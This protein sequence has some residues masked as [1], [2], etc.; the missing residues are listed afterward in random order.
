MAVGYINPQLL[1]VLAAQGVQLPG[2]PQQGAPPTAVPQ[3]NVDPLAPLPPPPQGDPRAPAQTPQEMA[4]LPMGQP[5][6]AP[7]ASSMNDGINSVGRPGD[8][9]DADA[10]ELRKLHRQ[11]KGDALMALGA[12]LLSANTFGEGL[13][14]GIQGY[15][16]V[17]Q[18]A[19]K[20]FDGKHEDVAGG[21]FD[22]YTDA[23]GHVHYNKN[24]DVA[25]Y[26]DNQKQ[27]VVDGKIY[28][29][30]KGYQKGVDVANITV[31]GGIKKTEMTT[32]AARDIA[33]GNN[34][35]SVKVAN[36][37]RAASETVANIMGKYR[38]IN[39]QPNKFEL[40]VLEG[41]Q[42]AGNDM[43]TYDN[44]ESLLDDGDTGAGAGLLA[45]GT[46]ALAGVTGQDIGG[47]NVNHM[48]QMTAYTNQMKAKAS[49]MKGQGQISNYERTIMDQ[50]LPSLDTNPDSIRAIIHVFRAKSDRDSRG[51]GI[52]P[53]G[54][55]YSLLDAVHGIKGQSEP[56][57]QNTT[58]TGTK[59]RVVH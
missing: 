8:Q 32:D 19:R 1:A 6:Q 26:L 46:R 24:K 33:A 55:E 56:A 54:T 10:K 14:K 22:K 30:D 9:S 20:E 18:N 51:V 15:M 12:G 47:V 11:S 39:R 48:Q 34:E 52:K 38:G 44:M 4:Q 43:Q 37:H 28:T 53:D 25:D 5:P 17:M 31:G 36:I 21:A 41:A 45:R 13:G 59:W 27:I 29:A 50:A 57:Q 2:V 40:Q 23:L 3:P 35:T 42:A 58:S 16:A 7:Q 49:L